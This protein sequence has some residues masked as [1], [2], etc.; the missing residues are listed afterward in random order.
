[1]HRL[2]A[3][4]VAPSRRKNLPAPKARHIQPQTPLSTGQSSSLSANPETELSIRKPVAAEREV[5]G[6]NIKH[7]RKLGVDQG[8]TAGR[9]KA[10]KK[11][12]KE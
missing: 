12:V 5:V 4:A 7:R 11:P 2:R 3:G 6:E 9:A 1:M 8:S 10:N